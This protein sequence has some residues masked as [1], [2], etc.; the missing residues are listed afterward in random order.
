MKKLELYIK[1]LAWFISSLFKNKS[2]INFAK[3]PYNFYGSYKIG[4]WQKREADS[5]GNPY[6]QLGI[7]DMKKAV[8]IHEWI[9]DNITYVTDEKQY[10][11]QDYWETS[12]EV[13]E[14]K[15]ADCEGIA[16]AH[17][18]LLRDAGFPD[19]AIGI[20]LVQDHAFACIYEEENDFWVLDNGNISSSIVRASE[21]FPHPRVGNPIA[22]FNLF[23]NW[24]Y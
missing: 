11:M 20:I 23:E 19:S 4:D 21:I 15:R 14:K 2:E 9:L 1:Y 12:T 6:K 18:R 17:W 3:K 10:G 24:S 5:S 22:G 13:L 8:K 7:I 16:A